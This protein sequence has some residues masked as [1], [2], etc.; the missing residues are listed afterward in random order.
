ME[1]LT[2]KN[3]LVIKHA[4]FDVGRM[5][6]IIGPQASGK[7][8]LAKLLY[9]FREFL[10]TD[11]AQSVRAFEKTNAL[12]R[13][14][15]ARFER[16]FPTY[17]WREQIFEL[18]YEIHGQVVRVSN[19]PKQ[20]LSLKYSSDLEDF[21]RDWMSDFQDKQAA[22]QKGVWPTDFDLTDSLGW[23]K[24]VA[25]QGSEIGECFHPSLFVPAGRSFFAIVQHNIF[26][27]LEGNIAIDPM[28][29]Q[30]GAKYEFSK[31]A[32]QNL[33]H[34]HEADEFSAV[35]SKGMAQ[36]APILA[37]EY[38]RENDEDW[39]VSGE[40]K[41]NISDASSG[42]QEAL[43]LLVTALL[44]PLAFKHGRGTALFVEDPEAHLFPTAQ[45]Q[46]LELLALTYNKLQHS[47]V[48]TTH[49][50]Y[51]LTAV[52]NLTLAKDVWDANP[53]QEIDAMPDPD[54]LIAYEDVR[55]YMIVEGELVT[56]MSHENRLIG[57]SAID[58]VSAEF[59]EVFDSLLQ[60]APQV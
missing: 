45:K 57:A 47:Y 50:P 27:L 60:H 16:L 20:S 17:G 35:R 29:Q 15:I 1:K 56:I 48:I 31:H 54:I 36:W 25:M 39:I 14:G 43:P 40:R 8:V 52:N 28:L 3:F 4:E 42:Q 30:F 59:D 19:V 2:V 37:G 58:G 55:A 18:E 26:A 49:S 12:E 21:R 24:A 6:F 44:W 23:V 53:G 34:N 51:I 10:Q 22:R 5:N 32:F 9:F 33:P 46:L 13:R 38:V 41:T 7:S 11:F